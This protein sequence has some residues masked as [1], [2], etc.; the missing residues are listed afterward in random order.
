MSEIKLLPCPFCNEE[1]EIVG[2]GHYFAHKIND[3]ILQ[4]LCFAKDDEEAIELWNTR[5][6]ME[7]I[8]E[9]FEEEIEQNPEA[10]LREYRAGFYKAI[11][12]CKEEGGIE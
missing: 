7:R 11:E 2:K 6:P 9:R 8:I 5:K 4:H 1:L 12:I 3:C 10:S